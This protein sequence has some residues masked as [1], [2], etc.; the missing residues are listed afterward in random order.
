MI[1]PKARDCVNVLQWEGCLP[2]GRLMAEL[3]E[4]A[5]LSPEGSSL[6]P[7]DP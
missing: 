1:S 6:I 4:V 3:D 5:H 7:G 2:C